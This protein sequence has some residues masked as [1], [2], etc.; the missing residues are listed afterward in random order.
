MWQ[1]QVGSRVERRARSFW[2]RREMCGA[3]K[4]AFMQERLKMHA[5]GLNP[6]RRR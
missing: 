2:R 3:L 4:Q 1:F 5:V 6:V